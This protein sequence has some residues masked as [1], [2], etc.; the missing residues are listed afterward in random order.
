[1]NEHKKINEMLTDFALGELPEQQIT[2]VQKHLAECNLCSTELKRLKSLLE[3]TEQV[4]KITV[5]KQTYH[6]AES[7]ILKIIENKNTTTT[8]QPQKRQE[9]I[10]RNIMKIRITKFAAVIIIA[11]VVL[12]LIPFHETTVLGQIIKN[13]TNKLARLR[14]LVLNEDIP[15]ENFIIENPIDKSVTTFSKS[16]EDSN[17][18]TSSLENYVNH[19]IDKSVKIFTQSNEY[20][21]FEIS[22]LENYLNNQN[23]YFSQQQYTNIKYAAIPNYMINN[24]QAFLGNQNGYKFVSSLRVTAYAGQEVMIAELGNCGL[25]LTAFQ[26]EN[27]ALN[28]DIAFYNGQDEFEIDQFYLNNEALLVSGLIANTNTTQDKYTTILIQPEVMY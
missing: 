14:A 28:M 6:A 5:D 12:G 27:N 23:I 24:L 16:S 13:T 7:E 17:S 8:P 21:S 10:W 22:S 26:D 3:Y 25:A 20:S 1:M 18:E 2:Q 15:V 11:F 9:N 19:Q 4:S